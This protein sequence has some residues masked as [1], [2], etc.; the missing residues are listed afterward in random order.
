MTHISTTLGKLMIR[1][2]VLVFR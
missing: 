1:A 2:K